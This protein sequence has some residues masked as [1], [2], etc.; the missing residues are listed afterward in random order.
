MR[1]FFS[2][3]E[4]SGDL[5]GADLLRDLKTLDPGFEATGLG[6]PRMAR[7]GLDAF[8]D[9]TRQAIIGFL[10]VLWHSPTLFRLIAQVRRIFDE[11][12]PDAFVPIDYPGLNLILAKMAHERGIPVIYYVSP[13]LWAWGRWRVP[14]VRRR[15][16]KLLAILPFE[17]EFFQ[18]RGIPTRY[19]GHPLVDRL[20][21]IE[22]SDDVV[23]RVSSRDGAPVL[24]LLPGSRLHEVEN[25]LPLMLEIAGR[26]HAKHPELRIVVPSPPEDTD[27]GRA[28]HRTIAEAS[29]T[30]AVA[31]GD[32]PHAV[33]KYATSCMVASGTAT[34][35]LAFYCTPMVILY[36]VNLPGRFIA[37]RLLQVQHIG[38]ANILAGRTAVPEFLFARPP[39][40]Q[41]EHEVTRQLFD[42][43]HRKTIHAELER[44]RE[45]LGPPGA[46]QRA[47]EAIV[48]HLENGAAAP[49]SQR[50]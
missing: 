20:S 6:G 15:V 42:E 33:M 29:S 23:A 35:E 49:A 41:I 43:A 40:E 16:D 37:S 4:A 34:A 9:L 32:H 44:V 24:G 28:I 13:Q 7:A 21:D 31:I 18:E 47:A 50:P 22:F 12:R 45:I 27:R 39:V 36:K 14:K 46:S 38:L 10:P 25:L 2:A 8:H 5:L 26:I 17:E 30:T 48:S 3:G 11:E 1:I 19:V